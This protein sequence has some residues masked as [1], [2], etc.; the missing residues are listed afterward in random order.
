MHEFC[1]EKTILLIQMSIY[2]C[3]FNLVVFFISEVHNKNLYSK[4]H[5]FIYTKYS[6]YVYVQ[7]YY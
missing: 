5:T 4:M 3:V 1:K 2:L 6:T 7:A